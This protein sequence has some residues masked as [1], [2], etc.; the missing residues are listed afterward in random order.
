ML[1]KRVIFPG[2]HY[3]HQL[4]LIFEAL[5]RPS[6]EDLAEVVNEQARTYIKNLNITEQRP[7][8][9]PAGTDQQAIDLMRKML[10]FTPGKRIKVDEALE[11]N[12]VSEYYRNFENQ[13]KLVLTDHR[14]E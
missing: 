11:H 12:Y 4:N 5:G 1:T 3:I 9:F 13:V 10:T 2:S 8:Q 6:E 7:I 14:S